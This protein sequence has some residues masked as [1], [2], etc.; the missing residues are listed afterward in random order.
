LP[1]KLSSSKTWRR[2]SI[3]VNFTLILVCITNLT[4]CTCVSCMIPSWVVTSKCFA[5]SAKQK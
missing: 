5:R 1:R 4:C 2:I 3:V